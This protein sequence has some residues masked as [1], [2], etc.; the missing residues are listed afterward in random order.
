M[1]TMSPNDQFPA[2]AEFDAARQI[3]PR[4]HSTEAS[5]LHGL[6]RE[7]LE[8]F[9]V[10]PE[11]NYGKRLADLAWHLY[12]GHA[13]LQSMYQAALHELADLP[14]ETRAQRFAAQKFLSY[15]LAKML[16]TLQQ[17]SRTAYQSIVQDSGQRSRKGPYPV[18]DNVTAIFS[19]QPVI[20]RTATYIFACA[21]W[22]ED[23][24]HG[25]ELMLEIY[26]RLLNPTNVSLANHIV[27]IE[28]GPYTA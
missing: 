2:A 1:T 19:A 5:D 24:F 18:F 27:D 26:S 21:E 9:G 13:D 15:Q 14:R 16:D 6:V 8:H 12:A 25:R 11:T 28:A 23:A 3:S 7:Q 17:S 20:T 22:V 10:D 4:R